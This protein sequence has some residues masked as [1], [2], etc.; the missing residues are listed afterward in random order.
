MRNCVGGDGGGFMVVGMVGVSWSDWCGIMD[1]LRDV[2][3]GG[4]CRGNDDDGW[5]GVVF[6]GAWDT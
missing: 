4:G 1:P 5:K 2:A 6:V 3:G